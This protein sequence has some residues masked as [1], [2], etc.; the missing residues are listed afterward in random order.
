MNFR[1]ESAGRHRPRG[2]GRA[3]RVL[4]LVLIAGAGAAPAW[5]G[6]AEA[7]QQPA[8]AAPQLDARHVTRRGVPEDFIF[9]SDYVWLDDR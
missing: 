9:A 6:I 3:A 1:S 2:R 8:D 7:F 5:M 4:G